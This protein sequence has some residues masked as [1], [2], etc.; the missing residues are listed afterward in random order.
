M[1]ALLLA[2]LVACAPARSGAARDQTREAPAVRL[3]FIG[4]FNLPRGGAIDGVAVGGISGIA[5]DGQH[6]FAL[7][8][9]HRAHGPPRIYRLRV[10]VDGE[11]AL[12]VEAQIV[13]D[14]RNVYDP[15]R[16]DPEGLAA[17]SGGWL[18]S[19]EGDSTL[20]PAVDLFDRDGVHRQRLEIPPHFEPRGGAGTR[21]NRGLEG[22]SALPDGSAMAAME[23]ALLQDG[24]SASETSGTCVRLLRY[25]RTLA[26]A[27]EHVYC[28]DPLPRV[29]PVRTVG[30]ALVGV[31]A[32]AFVDPGRLLVLERTALEIDG[33]FQNRVRIYAVDPDHALDVRG[34]PR[35]DLTHAVDKRL[36]IDLDAIASRLQPPRL[37]NFEAMALGPKLPSGERTLIIASDDNFA[38]DQRTAFVAFALEE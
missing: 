35:I 38:R 8:D 27:G 34:R 26:L 17:V 29:P 13:L 6:L 15:E 31:S 22:L 14:A 36:V 37:D 19:S 28:T 16:F 7:S 2:G 1:R 30:E 4:D 10:S 9:G 3:R 20:A 24:P 11:L 18:V 32:L 25:D 23:E 33:R 5:F 12:E 21:P